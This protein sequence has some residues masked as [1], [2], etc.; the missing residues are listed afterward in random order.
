MATARCAVFV[1]GPSHRP[2]WRD[3]QLLGSFVAAPRRL[4]IRL[5]RRGMNCDSLCPCRRMG[6]V[7]MRGSDAVSA[8]CS[9]MWTLRIG[10]PPI[11]HRG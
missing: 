4:L 9:A 10:Y 3:R 7:R 11:I 5:W 1:K 6:W 2:Q 8:S